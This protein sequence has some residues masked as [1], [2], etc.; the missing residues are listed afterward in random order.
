MVA[1]LGE[2]GSMV[3][4]ACAARLARDTSRPARYLSTI[5]GSTF[6][7]VGPRTHRVWDIRLPDTSTPADIAT[8]L[9][10]M[11]GEHGAGPWWFI[12]DTAA[13]TNILSPRASM[14]DADR[15]HAGTSQNGGRILL[16]GGAVAGRSW[17]VQP[18]TTLTLPWVD[19]SHRVPVVAGV[20]VTASAWVDG[21][22]A[23][24]MRLAVYRADGSVSRQVSGSN[25]PTSTPTRISVTVT[26]TSDEASCMI[27]MGGVSDSYRIARPAMS[28]T[29][30]VQPWAVGEGAEK[31]SVS[32]I[33]T[34][35]VLAIEGRT[36]V[37]ASFQV[38]EVG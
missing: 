11:E 5:G 13:V 17:I 35:P 23:A 26:P 33:S 27:F 6:A 28:F 15:V 36:Y 29:D 19:G 20:P 2:I 10:F 32:S 37:G 4:V 8:W 22:G 14:L 1:Y 7:Q 12:S 34:D 21:P 18:F 25:A 24:R 16:P 30:E 31:V 38:Q 9:S 3:E